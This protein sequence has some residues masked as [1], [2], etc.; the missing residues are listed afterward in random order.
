MALH[1]PLPSLSL[2]RLF[3]R[4]LTAAW[5]WSLLVGVGVKLAFLSLLLLRPPLLTPCPQHSPL[6]SLPSHL[7]QRRRSIWAPTPLLPPP[8]PRP[9][10]RRRRQCHL[11][12]RRASTLCPSRRR[13]WCEGPMRQH[14]LKKKKQKCK[15]QRTL[16]GRVPLHRHTKSKYIRYI[17][18]YTKYIKNIY[19]YLN[20]C[21]VTSNENA[22]D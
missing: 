20:L 7:Q 22:Y 17:Y 12:L 15:Q 5:A 8:L 10:P 11:P 3:P 1:R 6:L 16:K 19:I 4:P 9:C 13:C 14:K 2:P 21:A 18:I